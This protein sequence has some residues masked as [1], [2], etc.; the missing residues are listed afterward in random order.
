MRQL[1]TLRLDLGRAENEKSMS[2]AHAA[3]ADAEVQASRARI[4]EL[5]VHIG[6]LHAQLVGMEKAAAAGGAEWGAAAARDRME[7]LAHGQAVRREQIDGGA[8]PPASA[9]ISPAA[10]AVDGDLSR[11]LASLSGR[12]S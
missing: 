2:L 10:D 3:D 5:Q 1:A 6:H 9:G 7:H 8:G 11:Y 4:E 12:C